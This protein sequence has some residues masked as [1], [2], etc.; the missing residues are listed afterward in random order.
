MLSNFE[1]Q[2]IYEIGEVHL[3]VNRASGGQSDTT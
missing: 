1:P 3:N 2:N